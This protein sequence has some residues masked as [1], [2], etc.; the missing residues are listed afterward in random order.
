MSHTTTS[1][2]SRRE[3]GFSLVEVVIASAL[4]AVLVIIVSTLSVSGAD[5]QE[6]ARRLN[7]S[8]EITQDLIDQMRLELVS[9]VRLFGN[10]A[11]GNANLGVLDLSGAPTPLTG[12]ALP[13][14][15]ANGSIE[16][17]TVSRAITGNSLF[18]TRLAW[19]DRF[20][21]ASTNEYLVDVYR[22]VYYYL[23]PEDSGPQAGSAI[24]LNL[25]RIESEPLVDGV[26]V[27]RI[28][29]LTDQAE[30]LEHLANGTADATGAVR[31]PVQVVWNRGAD[32][33]V[34]GTFRQIDDSDGSMSTTPSGGRPDPWEVLRRDNDVRGLLSYRHH[35]VATVF[36]PTLQV[37]KYALED[38]SG[39]GFPH[40]FEVQVVGPSSARQVLVHLVIAS[41][42]RRG[43]MASANLQI[44]I[45]TRDL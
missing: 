33:A 38:T 1:H 39:V 44:V 11:E 21:C 3:S 23:T 6:Y 9:S 16:M 40:G 14:V 32:P 22:W 20:V 34:V 10:D 24:G 26:A 45:D 37:T 30:V 17:D 15:S 4:L 27:D 18:F 41:T 28:T 5:S 13:T 19:T 29:D 42:N 12:S 36:A 2:A 8:T 31:S 43:L 25:V 35:S 7:R